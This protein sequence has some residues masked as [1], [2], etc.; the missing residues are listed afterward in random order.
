MLVAIVKTKTIIQRISKCERVKNMNKKCK[1]ITLIVGLLVLVG[2]SNKTTNSESSIQADSQSTSISAEPT[3]TSTS[4]PKPEEQTQTSNVVTSENSLIS[5]ELPDGWKV[6]SITHDPVINDN[7]LFYDKVSLSKDTATIDIDASLDTYY[8]VGGDPVYDEPLSDMLKIGKYS[9]WGGIDNGSEMLIEGGGYLGHIFDGYG[10][11]AVTYF[12]P[13]GVTFEDSDFIS[14]LESLNIS[15]SYG[16]ATVLANKIN[17][18]KEASVD[19]DIV[20]TAKKGTSY[21]VRKVIPYDDYT[22]YLIGFDT[23]HWEWIADKE[24]EWIK[25]V[26]I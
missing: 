5:L 10:T 16:T 7:E 23:D 12:D 6:V 25:F 9:Y 19:S 22:W 15:D 14:I 8:G 1:N 2:C 3:P 24:G 13:K 18:R 26:K 20:G 11:L 4:T 17:I 21:K